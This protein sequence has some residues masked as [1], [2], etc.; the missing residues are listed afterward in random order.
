MDRIIRDRP[1]IFYGWV[2]VAISFVV[3][4]ASYTGLYSWPLFYVS[5]LEEFG[6][7]RAGT[8]LIFSFAGLVYAL[9]SPISGALFDRLGPR[10]LFTI[11]ASLITIGVVGCSQSSEVW[12]FCIFLG[13]FAALGLSAT[14]FTPN[15]ALISGWFEKKRAMA[16]GISAMGTRDTFL[17]A[18]LIQLIIIA[19]GWRNAY[20]VLAAF[21]ASIIPLA[22]FLRTRPQD[23]GLLPDGLSAAEDKA[24]TEQGYTDERIVNREWASTEWTLR[25]VLKKYQ[26]LP[27][28]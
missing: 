16:V 9:T 22:Q 10:K 11:G 25:K 23:M 8:A 17:L 7:S 3:M 21:A 18:P 27:N 26:N 1:K 5:I 4:T 15:V 14:G 20:L 24:R 19:L 28:R 13:L 12:Q 2:I 6:W